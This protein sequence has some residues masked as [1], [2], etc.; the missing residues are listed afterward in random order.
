M[1]LFKRNIL[2]STLGDAFVQYK[3]AYI[4]VDAGQ[5]RTTL[6]SHDEKGSVLALL[7]GACHHLLDG[8]SHERVHTCTQ[9]NEFVVDNRR[10]STQGSTYDT[11]NSMSHMTC[12]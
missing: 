11:E 7:L 5:L 3:N 6:L 12:V 2:P 8:A 4:G 1:S 10:G 9:D